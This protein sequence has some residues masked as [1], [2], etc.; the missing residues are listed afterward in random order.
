MKSSIIGVFM[1]MTLI[2]DVATSCINRKLFCLPIILVLTVAS[3]RLVQAQIVTTLPS[4]FLGEYP[5][6]EPV[7]NMN[8][9][10]WRSP[11]AQKKYRTVLI[12]Q[13]EIFLSPDSEYKGI[14]PNAFKII[15]DTL[16]DFMAAN[17]AE[18]YPVVREPGPGVVRVR[19]ALMD[20]RFRKGVE[21]S[22]FLNPGGAVENEVRAAIGRHISLVETRIEVELT[23]SETGKRLA[24]V[25]AYSGQ[26]KSDELGIPERGSSWTD[27]FRTLDRLN[28]VVR[29][30][31]ADLFVDESADP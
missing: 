12:E 13:P 11:D 29:L 9:Y 30:R 20:L 17:A 27:F 24:V 23:D 26:E 6:L 16:L 1:F 18:N 15:S 2:R 25:V 10:F 28:D 14:K 3:I 21:T 31:V 7:E 5:P 4:E 22:W 8:S 19:A